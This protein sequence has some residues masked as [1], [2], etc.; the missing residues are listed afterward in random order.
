MMTMM[1]V[2]TIEHVIGYILVVL[3]AYSFIIYKGQATGWFV[4]WFLVD[5]LWS[6]ADWW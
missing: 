4:D 6:M 1:I 3:A 2:N 5:W